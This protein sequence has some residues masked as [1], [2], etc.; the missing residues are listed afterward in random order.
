[1]KTK[2]KLHE[3]HIW[4]WCKSVTSYL[5]EIVYIDISI[6]THAHT[7]S[8]TRHEKTIFGTCRF[9][10]LNARAERNTTQTKTKHSLRTNKRHIHPLWM[11]SFVRSFIRICMTVCGQ[12]K[13]CPPCPWPL[14]RETRKKNLAKKLWKNNFCALKCW[15]N[16][17]N[18][19]CEWIHSIGNERR[20]RRNTARDFVNETPKKFTTS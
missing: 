7:H 16:N 9:F 5:F 12:K 13:L 18:I 14:H 15:E 11:H 8:H 4:I 3:N 6:Q 17:N 2:Q 10:E 19:F 20:R 1:M